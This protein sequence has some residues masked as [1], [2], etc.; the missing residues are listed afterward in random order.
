MK[1]PAEIESA[2]E[3]LMSGYGGIGSVE[4]LATPRLV[5]DH[6]DKAIVFSPD[7]RPALLVM[8]APAAYP[9]AVRDAFARAAAARGALDQG[10][11]AAAVQVA[12]HQG[13]AEGRSFAVVPYLTPIG[14]GRLRRRWDRWRL[15]G[16]VFEWLGEVT[17]RTS[18]AVPE[19]ELGLAFQAPLD[20][21]SRMEAVGG[22]V[23]EAAKDSL[24]ALEEGRWRPRWVLAHN[25]LWLGNFL[26][27]RPETPGD[28]AFAV[29]DWGASRVRG[30]PAYD[31]F[32]FANSVDL[33]ASAL[34]RR[35]VAY[36][37]ALGCPPAEARHHLLAALAAHSTALGE[38]PV[39]RFAKTA[40]RLLG[41][42]EAVR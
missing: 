11:A 7:G 23:R 33:S 4:L 10:A 27:R 32:S 35:L 30:Y 20:G 8:T 24:H 5:A 25:D 3:P 12:L 2:L 1:L 38:W 13:A 16:P 42:A 9:D 37:D 14:R 28:P 41:L 19:A 36:C 31:F 26:F 21:L 6:V 15:E 22:R 29:I 17:R 40:V 18:A 39:E 34:R